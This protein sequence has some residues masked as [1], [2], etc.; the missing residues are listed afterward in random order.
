[1]AKPVGGKL[2]FTREIAPYETLVFWI[3]PE[4]PPDRA[5]ATP[6][7]IEVTEE[8]GSAGNNV[9][10]RWT[11]NTEA[12]FYNY[13]V[14]RVPDT[15]N[16]PGVTSTPRPLRAALWVD[17]AVPPGRYRYRVYAQSASSVLSPPAIS[18]LIKV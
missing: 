9:L 11:P 7:W 10:L 8:P 3:I 1:P 4:P 15:P 16:A 14:E 5:P 12:F 2:T 17:T 13:I 6:T 18:P